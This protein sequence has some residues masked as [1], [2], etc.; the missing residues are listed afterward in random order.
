MAAQQDKSLIIEQRGKLLIVKFNR[1]K[2][3]NAMDDTIYKTLPN[4]FREAAKDDNI[5]VVALTGVGEFYSS[6]NDL[7]RSIAIQEEDTDLD[8][9]MSR[10]KFMI[11][12]FIRSFYTFPKLLV[13]VV[14]GPC[15]GVAATTAAL[16]DII[17]CS[18]TAYFCTPFVKLGICAEGGSSYTFPKILGKSKAMEMLLCNHKLTADE[19]LKFNFVSEIF[20]INEIDKI[21]SKLIEFSKLPIGALRTTKEL[22]QNIDKNEL[23]KAILNEAD[24]LQQRWYTNEFFEA[25]NSYFNSKL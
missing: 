20:Q 9:L 1:P 13:A 6:G 19:A 23:E 4:I 14:N 3:K 21:W 11:L 15:F 25:I 2:K 10:K 7:T 24:A 12:D 16:C 18:N 5:T 8:G 17:Y 22:I